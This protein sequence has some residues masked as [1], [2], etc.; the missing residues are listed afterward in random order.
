L[1]RTQCNLDL[2][3]WIVDLKIK[4]FYFNLFSRLFKRFT[5]KTI[6]SIS[7]NWQASWTRKFEQ[8]KL[9]IINTSKPFSYRQLIILF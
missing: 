6:P 8:L 1:H 2:K 5:N 9:N 7:I 4:L 3:N